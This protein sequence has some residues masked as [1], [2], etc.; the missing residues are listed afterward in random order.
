MGHRKWGR[1]WGMG[2]EYAGFAGAAVT[3]TDELCNVMPW[4]RGHW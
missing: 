1:A 2:E 4:L 3:N